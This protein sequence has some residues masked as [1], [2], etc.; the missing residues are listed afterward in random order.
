[1][2]SINHVVSAIDGEQTRRLIT[3][4]NSAATIEKAMMTSAVVIPPDDDDDSGQVVRQEK[5]EEYDLQLLHSRHTFS[6]RQ[7]LTDAQNNQKH[8]KKSVATGKL[9]R[10]NNHSV[11]IW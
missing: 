7:K 6:S 10:K 4:E 8:N 1:M 11:T 3:E 5:E 9:L 2:E